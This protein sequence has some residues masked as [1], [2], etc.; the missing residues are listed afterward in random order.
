MVNIVGYDLK[1]QCEI[2]RS[3]RLPAA[4]ERGGLPDVLLI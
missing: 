1:A 4:R 3:G 2:E